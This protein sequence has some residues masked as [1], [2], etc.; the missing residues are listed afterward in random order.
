MRRKKRPVRR[1]NSNAGLRDTV[2]KRLDRY[3]AGAQQG[4]QQGLKAGFSSYDDI[5][6]GT[7]IIIPA[8]NEVESVK[9]CIEG[10]MDLT[11]L[12]YEIIVIDNGS[13]D[14]IEHYLKQ[15][16]GQV[17]YRILAE[18]IGFTG[19]ANRGF[20]MAKGTTILLL[21]NR[22]CPA[23]DW[24][25]NMLICLNSDEGIGIV[26]PTYNESYE[27]CWHPAEKLSAKC[28][29][30]R[31]ELLEKVGYLDEGFQDASFGEEDFCLRVRLQGYSLICAKDVYVHLESKEEEN[32]RSPLAEADSIDSKHE[33]SNKWSA[34][35]LKFLARIAGS[36]VPPSS[37][38]A[39]EYDVRRK[40]GEA[41]FYPQQIAVKGLRETIYWIEKGSRRPIEGEWRQP[42]IQL[43]QIDLWRWP[44]GMPIQTEATAR[45]GKIYEKMDGSFYCIE[46]GVKRLI[47][48][49]YA[50]EAWS[51]FARE[52]AEITED[53]LDAIPEGAPIISP[54]LLRQSL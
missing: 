47:V 46:N 35:S 26:G 6:E 29:L 41:Y 34:L 31:R 5:F 4:Y 12:P 23:E 17:R 1:L 39:S 14:G 43:S 49:R 11:E 8:H 38:L 48:N 50:A 24:L 25:A 32:E 15:L 54:I 33:H 21:S 18:N 27:S 45:Q 7:S 44:I 42:I 20:M 9:R 30:F 53:E 36:S 2:K 22:I 52:H 28:L 37:M 51:L 16:D 10:I 3:K 40:L 13:S 19:A